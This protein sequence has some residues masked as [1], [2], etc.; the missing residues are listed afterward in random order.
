MFLEAGRRVYR[1]QFTKDLTLIGS[2]RSNDIVIRDESV[3]PS[4]AQISRA[5]DV[6]TLRPLEDAE[7]RV[8]GEEVEAAYELMNGNRIE[9][10]DTDILFA[11]EMHES[12]TTVHLIIRK[13]GEP[14]MGFWT[15]KS[16]I[17]VG[18]ERGD[19]IVDDPLLSKVH[20]IV[21]NFCEGGQFL[22]D[23]RSERGTGLNGE[24]IEARCR[25][26]DGDLITVGGVEIEFRCNPYASE[27]GQDAAKLARERIGDLRRAGDFRRLSSDIDG[28]KGAPR[29]PY[30]RYPSALP[31][32][33]PPP[34]D[35]AYG[36]ESDDDVGEITRRS[37]RKRGGRKM[38]LRSGVQTGIVN[39]RAERAADRA[40]KQRRP[41]RNDAPLPSNSPRA[42]NAPAGR[43]PDDAEAESLPNFKP[44]PHWGDPKKRGKGFGDRP[45]EMDTRISLGNADDS[46]LWYVPG[47]KRVGPGKAVAKPIIRARG[48]KVPTA[49]PPEVP[50]DSDRRRPPNAARARIRRPAGGGGGGGPSIRPMKPSSEPIEQPRRDVPPP[51]RRRDAPDAPMVQADPS[52]S[53]GARPDEQERW[54][55]PE[56]RRKPIRQRKS[57]GDL[58]YQPGA[59][60]KR[61]P[62]GDD[63]DDEY[64]DR[65]ERPDPDKKGSLTQVFDGK[66][67]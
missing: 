44:R 41:A 37:S 65:N 1:C 50:N 67:Y 12:P 61:R 14:P 24:S 34:R 39:T 66:D 22:L 58:W 3:E 26:E 46:G 63:Y 10:G 49:P 42:S 11:R 31:D 19:I 45:N 36:R 17:V 38:D 6:Y 5:R 27:Q 55:I 25:L 28:P 59:K 40:P 51:P 23:A 7:V 21:E 20:T 52:A 4:H 47:G 35:E 15:S 64:G 30:Q 8:D 2:D 29:N 54:Y 33:D 16:T 13:P 56:E 57:G 9:I 53:P 18:R 60:K 32:A 43:R 62:S 48:D